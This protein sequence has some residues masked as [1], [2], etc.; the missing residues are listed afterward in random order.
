MID[1]KNLCRN[2]LRRS[3]PC[4]E[5]P[6]DQAVQDF[7]TR[8]WNFKNLLQLNQK[9]LEIMSRM[10]KALAGSQVYGFGF[11]RKNI[12]EISVSVFRVISLMDK[13]SPGKYPGLIERFE[14]IHSRLSN[15]EQEEMA[16]RCPSDT[17][18]LQNIRNIRASEAVVAG[19]KAANLGE[20]QSISGMK[21][22]DGFALSCRAYKLFMDQNQLAGQV[23]QIIQCVDFESLHQVY[24][25]SRRLQELIMNSAVPPEVSDEI[26][27]AVET[28]QK[29][30]GTDLKFAVRSSATGE[31]TLGTSFAGQYISVLDV[32]VSEL[33]Q[34]YK[35]VLA[36]KYSARA[37]LY[38]HRRGLSD[39]HVLMG[40]AF[41]IMQ[42]AECSGVIYTRNP[43]TGAREVVISVLPGLPGA[44]VDGSAD[45][46]VFVCP[47]NPEL[48][49]TRRIQLQSSMIRHSPE[50][51]L[52][53]V[54]LDQDIASSP[55][56]SDSLARELAGMALNLEEHF[57]GP[58][59][60]EWCLTPEGQTIVLQ[61]RPLQIH[62]DAPAGS[63]QDRAV[64]DFR[65][66]IA[67]HGPE[68]VLQG[69]TPACSGIASGTVY[70]VSS[71][72][73]AENLPQG[74]IMVARE[75]MPRWSA[76]VGRASGI[77]TEHGSSAGHLATVAREFHVPAL[78][79]LEGA[80]HLLQQGSEI[81]LDAGEG[82]VYPGVL[83]EGSIQDTARQA[84][85]GTPVQQA[86]Q[87][88]IELISPLHLVDPSGDGFDPEHCQSFHDILRFCHEKAVD[89]MFCL[90]TG[91][92]GTDVSGKRLVAG[93]ETQWWLVDIGGGFKG[94]CPGKKIRLS[95][96]CSVPFLMVW[97]G[98]I[99]VPWHGPPGSDVKG[100][101]SIIMES[102]MNRDLEMSGPSC[103]Q[104]KNFALLAAN[105]CS[106]NC[107]FGYHYS[108]LQSLCKDDARENYIRFGF[109]GGAADMDRK[110]LRL[111]LIR[112]LLEQEGFLVKGNEDVLSASFEGAGRQETMKRLKTL[113]Y[114]MVHT[115]QVDMVMKNQDQY[116]YYLQKM[117][118]DI[119]NL[120]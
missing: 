4:P 40:A 47:E 114:I 118:Q 92:Q 6:D 20:V 98:M 117:Q 90:G 58:Q 73:D 46:D 120:P 62:Q 5:E 49:V 68:P 105:F 91:Y 107:R 102:T 18:L 1:F 8:Y 53:T 103:F 72:A 78:F 109:K 88:I 86:L 67:A 63:E 94:Q 65:E 84:M 69:G 59:D 60:I 80:A 111:K 100:M 34:A 66:R 97:E 108:V 79:N 33:E 74:A 81:T 115:R 26:S 57:C 13:I 7:K 101:F 19:A 61:S 95:Q 70:L 29:Q 87:R 51:G 112:T 16:S 32:P 55:V 17:W 14:D 35:Q 64:Q 77:I 99:S 10:E 43:E 52:T 15:I 25:T 21:I 93:A 75:A 44:L 9:V 38:R 85:R 76:L 56:I 54:P 12:S 41:L 71:T 36:G 3:R 39:S 42:D 23:D 96:V 24:E 48:P 110:R 116:A 28:L 50:H 27:L 104:M 22:P 31:D 37:M 82:A 113:G 2:L 11:V 119:S 45:P 30:H 83:V 106:M 89:E